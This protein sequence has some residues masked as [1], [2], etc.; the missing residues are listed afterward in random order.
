MTSIIAQLIE[1]QQALRAQR[2]Y[3]L[4]EQIIDWVRSH[5]QLNGLTVEQEA[6]KGGL[7]LR[8]LA[9]SDVYCGL[10]ITFRAEETDVRIRST[11]WD[12]T[13]RVRF[14]HPISTRLEYRVSRSNTWTA[15][16][17]EKVKHLFD[18]AF[19]ATFDENYIFGREE[20]KTMGDYVAG[21]G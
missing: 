14:I 3:V 19:Q 17:G 5:A 20:M 18:A 1:I 12:R 8:V 11:R 4:E 10:I 7:K 6:T 13:I 16:S 9:N 21:R 2:F 15:L